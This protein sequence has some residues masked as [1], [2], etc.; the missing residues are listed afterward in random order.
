[1]AR[2]TANPRAS[3]RLLSADV[4]GC[5]EAHMFLCELSPKSR[6]CQWAASV[7]MTRLR[8]IYLDDVIVETVRRQF[9]QNLTTTWEI[10]IP[11]LT[12]QVLLGSYAELWAHLT[13]D[14]RTQRMSTT[15]GHY[16]SSCAFK[17]CSITVRCNRHG[18]IS[19]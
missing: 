4:Q 3:I 13:S 9:V 2:P 7:R 12:S 14:D 15:D 18:Q 17:I 10:A 16:V 5:A 8:L 19:C 11:P 1:L 6:H